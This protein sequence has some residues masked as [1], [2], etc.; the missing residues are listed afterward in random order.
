M[1]DEF[2]AVS[3]VSQITTL[4]PGDR[5]VVLLANG[6][7][8]TVNTVSMFSNVSLLVKQVATPSSSSSVTI[9]NNTIY[10]T[11]GSYI[12]VATG[13]NRLGRIAISSSGT[14]ESDGER[15][16][17]RADAAY[18]VDNVTGSDSNDGSAAWPFATLKYAWK[19]LSG[20]LDLAQF[21]LTIHLAASGT[22]Y[23]LNDTDDGVLLNGWVGGS[24]VFISG[25]GSAVTTME[26]TTIG[27][28]KIFNIGPG[29]FINGVTLTEATLGYNYY[30]TARGMVAFFDP[31]WGVPDIVVGHTVGE[32]GHLTIGN[33][34][35]VLVLS[36][37]SVTSDATTHHN[38]FA[39]GMIWVWAEITLI[40]SRAFV[41][42][43]CFA[44]A[45]AV[46]DYSVAT[47]VGS[48][49]GQ[50]YR[51]ESNSVV[52]PPEGE[53]PGDLPGVIESGGQYSG[54]VG[55]PALSLPA[56]PTT[57]DLMPGMFSVFKD[58]SGGGVVIAY[59]DAGTIKTA[60][61]T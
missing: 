13:A 43:F 2:V 17:L 57:A 12:Y 31:A 36:N 39:G 52:Y 6:V 3:T 40:G 34:G 29:I 41:Q 60:A 23:R 4:S 22:P 55:E 1:T 56:A 50:K 48:A 32:Y 21:S 46:I 26:D 7:V 35:A 54:L 28:D 45:L 51:V 15:K 42:D 61:L 59:N 5:V 20:T 47:F 38:A 10:G 14:V 30:Q 19:Y 33:S 25:A 53:L 27:F 18:Y 24:Y 58:T 11:D 8:R 49:T 16:L 37:Y 9:A 44:E